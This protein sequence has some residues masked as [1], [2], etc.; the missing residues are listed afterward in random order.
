MTDLCLPRVTC[1]TRLGHGKKVPVLVG[2]RDHDIALLLRRIVCTASVD[3]S[4]SSSRNRGF[5]GSEQHAS[6][7]RQC[8]ADDMFPREICFTSR[9]VNLYSAFDSFGIGCS[10]V[11]PVHDMSVMARQEVKEGPSQVVVASVRTY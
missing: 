6:C 1:S 10:G 5:S 8:S 2:C 11:L 3:I 4:E 7:R 9:P